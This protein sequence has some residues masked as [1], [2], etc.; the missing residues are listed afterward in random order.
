[1]KY[2]LIYISGDVTLTDKLTQDHVN[3]W[4]GRVFTEIF[5]CDDRKVF[6][7]DKD[8][9]WVWRFPDIE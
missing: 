8:G 2:L 4:K 9:E 1:M 5:D 7:G 6:E 3:K